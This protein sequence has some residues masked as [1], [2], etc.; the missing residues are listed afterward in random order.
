MSDFL[1]HICSKLRPFSEAGWYGLS[2]LAYLELCTPD[3]MLE[4]KRDP[5]R[6][7]GS[8]NSGQK[9]NFGGQKS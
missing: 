1:L 8:R 7:C 6:T 3:G 5:A 9:V 4:A 2:F